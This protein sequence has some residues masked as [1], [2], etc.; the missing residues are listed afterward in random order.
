VATDELLCLKNAGTCFSAQMNNQCPWQLKQSKSWGPF[1][2]YH[3]NSTTYQSSQFPT[4]MGQM[5]R[6]G[7]AVKLVAIKQGPR[8]SI[9]SIAMGA[10]PL[11]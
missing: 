10:K 6:I 9:F 4:K 11:F 3:L 7:S 2:S 8:T 5:G 1:W